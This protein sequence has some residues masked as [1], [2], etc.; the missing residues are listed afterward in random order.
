MLGEDAGTLRE[1]LVAALGVARWVDAVAARAPFADLPELLA[2]ARAEATPLSAAEIDEALAHHPRI[3][4][5]ASGEG[6]AQSFSRAEQASADADDAEVNAAI[7]AG[8]RAYEDRFGRVFLIR[9]AG[10]TRAEILAELTRR[11]DLAPEEELDVVAEQLRQ[12]MELRLTTLFGGE[13]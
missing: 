9:A 13:A 4:E 7:A 10:R 12:I 5:R 11:L 8:N 2:V 1:A 6:R 3:G